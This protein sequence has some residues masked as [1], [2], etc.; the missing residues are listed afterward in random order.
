MRT[1]NCKLAAILIVLLG[2]AC[3]P[4]AAANLMA[5]A[6]VQAG[7][8][9]HLDLSGN[10]DDADQTGIV[11]WNMSSGPDTI[12]I[13]GLPQT[14]LTAED[15]FL[16]LDGSLRVTTNLQAGE[17]R[18]LL[19]REYNEV[20]V[21]RLRRRALLRGRLRVMRRKGGEA[22]YRRARL[23]ARRMRE[24]RLYGAPVREL[25]ARRTGHLGRRGVDTTKS[26]VW[27]VVDN[28]SDFGVGAP[29]PEPMSMT[30]LLAGAAGLLIRRRRGR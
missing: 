10:P 3:G 22:R 23:R 21:R 29:V 26:Y 19:L 27:A 15:G 18:V 11:F 24:I 16:M 1:S 14:D 5:E 25:R 6:T 9:V 20:R 28:A 2:L 4:A 13:E 30:I 7:Q 12:T 17:F 8:S